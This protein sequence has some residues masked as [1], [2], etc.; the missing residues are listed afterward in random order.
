MNQHLSLWMMYESTMKKCKKCEIFNLTFQNK[1]PFI[2]LDV[3]TTDV[4]EEVILLIDSGSSDAIW[5]FNDKDIVNGALKK[6]FD[7]FLGQGLSGSI[8][9]KRSKLKKIEIGDFM[10]KNVKVAFPNEESME[11]VKYFEKRDG[12]LGGDILKR[13]TVI[14]DY[15]NQK[16]SLKRNRKFKAP[17]HYNMS[18]L[19]LIHDGVVL[20]R[21]KRSS[22]NELNPEGTASIPLS[23]VYDFY[24]A[25]RFIVSEIRENS[26]A[27]LA[28]IFKG[29]EIVS[30]N[31]KETHSYKLQDIIGL[32]ASKA[33]K[34][35]TVKIKRNGVIFTKKFYLKEML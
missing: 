12:S 19:T 1:K 3:T 35:I 32:F 2:N 7:D 18:G 22:I 4:T 14:M 16:I 23:S 24:L 20:V 30:I 33:N 25:P 17:F 27:E 31:G 10:L 9:G 5:L 11:N 13:F 15:P 6:Y 28:G 21:E 26:P 29:D 34:K 8:F